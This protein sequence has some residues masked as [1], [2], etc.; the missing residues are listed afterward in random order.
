MKLSTVSAVVALGLFASASQAADEEKTFTMD[1]EL[2]FIFTSGNTET[3]SVNG[4][5][6]AK[7]E[8][9]KWS[10]EYVLT[11][12]Y[13]K[14]EIGGVE[15][16]SA[17]KKFASAQGNYRLENPAYRLFVFGSY[18]DNRLSSYD[19]QA[20]IAAGWNHKVWAD[21]TSSFE[22]SIGP[23]YSLNDRIDVDDAGNRIIIEENS[24]VVRGALSYAYNISETAKF[25]QSFS[26]EVGSD[27]TKS[28]AESAISAKLAG[29]L[30]LKVAIRFDHNSDVSEGTE[31]LDT[32]TAVNLVYTFF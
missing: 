22:Y 28:R 11:A 12:L 8:L 27:N 6:N 20:T 16:T 14:D 2:G 32:E 31:N 19:F 15:R 21:D 1:G 29:A 18:E 7:Q 5:L 30:S 17:D 4:A 9:E 3:T 10:N 13:K 25:T 23:G 26:T 24:V